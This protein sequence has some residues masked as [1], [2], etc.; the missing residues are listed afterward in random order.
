[1]LAIEADG[2]LRPSRHAYDRRVAGVVSGSGPYRPGIVLNRTESSE[3]RA[4]VALI[5][6]VMCKVDAGYG[7]IETG[8]LLTT[9]ETPGHAMKVCDFVRAPGA[10]VGKALQGWRDGRGLIPILVALQ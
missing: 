3:P 10:I 2:R 7:A 9:S 4:A 1:L 5:G 6:R 8:D